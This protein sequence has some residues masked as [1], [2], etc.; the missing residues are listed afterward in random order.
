MALVAVAQGEAPPSVAQ[1]VEAVLAQ[2]DRTEEWAALARALRCLLEG[3]RDPQALA[4]GL[5][6]VDM[7]A[8]ALTL[9][10]LEGEEGR[11]LL[12]AL[13]AAGRGG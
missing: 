6:P 11:A 3:E 8:L 4:Q 7:Q 2:M 5:D 9:A 1:Q 10:A 13:A 12:E